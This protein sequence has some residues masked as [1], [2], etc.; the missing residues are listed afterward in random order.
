MKIED[1]KK[2]TNLNL[3]GTVYPCMVFGDYLNHLSQ[4]LRIWY[5]KGVRLFKF[6]FAYFD[7][8]SAEAKKKFMRTEIIEKKTKLLQKQVLRI[9]T[10]RL[11][12]YVV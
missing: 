7:D 3:N 6:D 8:A 12:K 9:I 10:V 4:T 5:D 1:F 11:T 2:V